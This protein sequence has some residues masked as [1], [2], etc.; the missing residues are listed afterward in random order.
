MLVVWSH[1][2]VKVVDIFYY[3]PKPFVLLRHSFGFGVRISLIVFESFSI[4]FEGAC[5]K[6]LMK[7]WLTRLCL[8]SWDLINI[9]FAATWYIIHVITHGLFLSYWCPIVPC[10]PDPKLLDYD[11]TGILLKIVIPL[12]WCCS[13]TQFGCLTLKSC[14][15][16]RTPWHSVNNLPYFF[17]SIP[18]IFQ[19]QWWA[20]SSSPVFIFLGNL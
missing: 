20:F 18:Y 10:A 9:I 15:W 5:S 6:M 2:I 4:N 3:H 1:L 8:F 14:S 12:I 17:M 13:P 19:S 11:S 7:Q 16:S